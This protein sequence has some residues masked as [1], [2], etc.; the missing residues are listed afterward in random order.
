MTK[1]ENAIYITKIQHLKYWKPRFQR[2]YFGNEFCP[3]LIPSPEEVKKVLNFATKHHLKFSLL[4][5]Q[6]NDYFLKKFFKIFPLLG[7]ENEI[8]LNDWGILNII[9]KKFKELLPSCVLGKFL[10][11]NINLIHD[12]AQELLRK[13][14]FSSVSLNRLEVEGR[15]FKFDFTNFFTILGR[16]HPKFKISVYYPYS[17]LAT[18]TASL[19]LTAH[20]DKVNGTRSHQNNFSCQKECQKYTFLADHPSRKG[21]KIILKGNTWFIKQPLFAFIKKSPRIDR[22]V[23]MPTIPM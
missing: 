11:N 17:Y 21:K 20:C 16:P 14:G 12:S 18:T 1:P 19:C 6:V 22:L 4:T 8:I 15:N 3:S 7:K 13:Q 23:Y 5:C 10:T 2:I 9:K